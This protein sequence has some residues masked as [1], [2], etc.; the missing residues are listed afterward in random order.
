MARSDESELSDQNLRYKD[1]LEGI[2][3]DDRGSRS[4]EAW[5]LG[6]RAENIDELENLILDSLRD[7]A[8]WRRNYQPGDPVHI[9]EEIRQSKDFKDAIGALRQHHRSLLALLKK[10][11]PFFSMRYQGHMNWDLTMAAVAGYFAAMLYNPNN[12]AFE[13]S[14]ATTI[15]EMLVG[16]DLC[17]MLGLA[18]TANEGRHDRRIRPWGHIT[19][20]GTLANIEAIWAARNLKYY[21]L[22]IRQALRSDPTLA[23]ARDTVV[24]LVD[25]RSVRLIDADD[26]TLLNLRAD[27]TLGLPSQL[28]SRCQIGPEA[29][30][31][32]LAVY[33]LQQLGM[34][35]VLRQQ[36]AD[37]SRLPVFLV[38]GTK[39]YSFTK[40]SA[41]LGLGAANMVD[42]A[43][44]TRARMD[45][46]KLRELLQRFLAAKQPVCTVV[47]VM[48]STEESAV[49]PISDVLLLRDEF[50]KKGLEF[51]IH[52]DAAWGG[53]HASLIREF[54]D[55][56][57]AFAPPQQQPDPPPQVPLSR[58]VEK[59]FRSLGGADSITVDPHKSGYIPY[60][61]G[62]LCYRNSGMRD[63]VTFSAPVVYHG[64][65]EPTVGIFG[66]EGS[67]PGASAAA[68][69]L[70]H[71]V[72]RPTRD[73]Y[74]R[75][76]GRALYSC[77]RLYARL[78]CM[79]RPDDPFVITPIPL[80]PVEDECDASKI[81]QVIEE[82]RATIDD[83]TNSDISADSRA[84]DLLSQIGPDQNILSY[85]FNFRLPDM[86]LNSQLS[87]ANRLNSE[88]YKL[89]SIRPGAD[90]YGY[91]LIVST[92]D[93]NEANYG[94]VF[95]TKLKERMGV[96]KSEGSIVTVLRSV[97]MD[98]W[99]TETERG[100]F[101]DI[102]EAE[103]R[104]AVTEAMTMF[105]NT[106][107]RG[108]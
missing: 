49:D 28:A 64:Q 54:Y 44:D 58:Y 59:Q 6:P 30:S 19:A 83:R 95:L 35:E 40:A 11:V 51:T 80:L 42:V 55:F 105:R 76:I 94:P 99:V 68:V 9:T 87:A 25:G 93:L 71:K 106:Y 100:S 48:G 50:R 10:S 39:H 60:P 27:D 74:G 57:H 77:K 82:I 79:A 43:V 22:S 89:L 26:W 84:F 108:Y 31:R 33:S 45:V 8:Y 2:S 103:F 65:T 1:Y 86:S 16:D 5:F 41:L 81:L 102:L 47:C 15:L 101:I 17:R 91:R 23:A 24:A 53:Y 88:I 14:T 70:S 66:I 21:P 75:V 61:A 78:L 92:T 96:G 62:A 90:I 107:M 52:A 38:P 3:L 98:P 4:V 12:V 18:P 7:H 63:V 46:R 36:S 67:K 32:S 34:Y 72:I 69:Y 104:A 13:G 73:G 56:P 85:A 97:V 29:I 20:D 37:V